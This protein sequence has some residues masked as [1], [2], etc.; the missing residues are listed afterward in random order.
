MDSNDLLMVTAAI[1]QYLVLVV[2]V[3][4]VYGADDHVHGGV[5]DGM[6]VLVVASAYV[7]K[8]HQVN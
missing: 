6:L 2:H 8:Y 7:S 3:D 1:I 4:D 5:N